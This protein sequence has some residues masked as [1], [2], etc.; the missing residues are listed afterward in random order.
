MTNIRVT[1]QRCGAGVPIRPTQVLL[2]AE[3]GKTSAAYLFL[4]PVCERLTV[5]PA[6]AGQVQML[7]AAG[8]P[9]G[10]TAGPMTGIHRAAGRDVWPTFT[11]DD[12]LD[13]HLLLAEDDWFSRLTESVHPRLPG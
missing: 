13:L 10:S 11:L 12:L 6:Q 8:V 9:V 1:C 5:R 2:L 3:V 4:C 7:V